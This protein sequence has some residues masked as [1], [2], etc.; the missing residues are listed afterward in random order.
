[1]KKRA[2]FLLLILLFIFT[3]CESTKEKSASE[4]VMILEC[5]EEGTLA[6]I[7]E[8]EREELRRR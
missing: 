4:R 7:L 2:L 5:Q 1:M 3:G 6:F 8:T